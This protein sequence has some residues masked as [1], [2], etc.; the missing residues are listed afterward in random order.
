MEGPFGAARQFGVS[1]AYNALG[2]DLAPTL[3]VPHVHDSPVAR[4][5]Y[6]L[7]IVQAG[8]AWNRRKWMD[9]CL[10]LRYLEALLVDFLGHPVA[11]LVVNLER[12]GHKV[13]AFL[14]EHEILLPQSNG[15]LID[16]VG[17][18]SETIEVPP[19]ANGKMP[20]THEH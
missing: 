12:S 13:I 7:S 15:T 20:A 2:D 11:K 16:D 4:L 8:L 5:I 17:N 14:L 6:L 18:V 9:V 1:S 19:S 10:L 3:P